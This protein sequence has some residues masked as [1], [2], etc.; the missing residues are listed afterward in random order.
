[1]RPRSTSA[2]VVVTVCFWLPSTG[3]KRRRRRGLMLARAAV[4][5]SAL[6]G[7]GASAAGAG[8]AGAAGAGAFSLEQANARAVKDT[9]N[10]LID[11]PPFRPTGDRAARPDTVLGTGRGNRR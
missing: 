7:A 4:L 1:M 6:A 11:E 5:T 2:C 8:A 3:W 10:N 9:N